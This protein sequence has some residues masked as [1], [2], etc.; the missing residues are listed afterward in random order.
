MHMD[1]AYVLYLKHTVYIFYKHCL[2]KLS[3]SSHC[4]FK[5]VRSEMVF[6]R[7]LIA[8]LLDSHMHLSPAYLQ[9]HSYGYYTRSACQTIP[10]ILLTQLPRMPPSFHIPAHTSPLSSPILKHSRLLIFHAYSFLF[11]LF[12]LSKS[13]L[14]IKS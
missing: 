1:Y 6:P 10:Q 7:L 13:L 9:F 12:S 4:S 5:K 11:S 8:F 14:F 2:P 3:L